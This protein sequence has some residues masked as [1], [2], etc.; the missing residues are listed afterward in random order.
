MQV[1]AATEK[2]SAWDWIDVIFIGLNDVLHDRDRIKEEQERRK[3][4]SMRVPHDTAWTMMYQF[5]CGCIC[6][7]EQE[8][9]L[10][11]HYSAVQFSAPLSA[12]VFL[13]VSC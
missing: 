4:L 13:L 11:R 2:W 3:L 10:A 1:A 12:H 7:T 6:S 8:E 9:G 5:G